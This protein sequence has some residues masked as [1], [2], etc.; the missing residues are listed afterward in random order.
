MGSTS[1]FILH[2]SSFRRCPL[3]PSSFA[4]RPSREA[5]VPVARS[6]V[7]RR[8][9]FILLLVGLSASYIWDYRRE[10]THGGSQMGIAYGVAGTLVIL[11][12][13][14]FGVRKRWY[15]STFGT[16]EQWMQS[17]IYLGVLS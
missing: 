10:Y 13:A 9:I 16:L 7:L 3:R 5:L 1:S 11:L 15:R 17:H 4:L 8:R 14:F 6:G 2:P 12:L